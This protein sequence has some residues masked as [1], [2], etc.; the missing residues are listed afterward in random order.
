[1]ATCAERYRLE[2]FNNYNI[3]FSLNNCQL[4]VSRAY[5]RRYRL[6]RYSGR[7]PHG[8]SIKAFFIL[9]DQV[10]GRSTVEITARLTDTNGLFQ[11]SEAIVQ[12]FGGFIVPITSS[13]FVA[14]HSYFFALCLYGLLSGGCYTRAA[15]HSRTYQSNFI[16]SCLDLLFCASL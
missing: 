12:I 8:I 9:L 4:N 5:R 10:F 16:S 11:L 14:T 1:M 6:G 3:L 2:S 7:T 13:I 15:W